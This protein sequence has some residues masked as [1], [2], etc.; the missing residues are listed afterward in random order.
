MQAVLYEC[1]L[2]E[3]GDCQGIRLVSD[4]RFDTSGAKSVPTR[5]ASWSVMARDVPEKHILDTSAWNALFDDAERE[6][7][8][9]ILRT[10]T[11]LPTCVAI[12]ELAAIEDQERRLA[13]L[14]LVKALGRDNRPLAT[15]NQLII[16]GCQGYARR[17]KVLTINSGDDA[18]GAWIAINKPERV[19]AVAQRMALEF[20]RER[21]GVFRS[22]SEG[23]RG[24]LQEIFHS[25]TARPRSMVL[26]FSTMP[27]MISYIQS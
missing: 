27:R 20:N 22:W 19:D 11:I 8:I 9:D 1:A 13:L 16:L 14:R 26:L 23:L 6:G 7:I 5:P 18:E 15:P 3:N 25:G 10:K 21:E 2:S 24:G 12:S 4:D 17:D